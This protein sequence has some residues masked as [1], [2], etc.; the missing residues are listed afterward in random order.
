MPLLLARPRRH[1]GVLLVA[2][3]IGAEFAIA[4]RD[5]LSDLFVQ[6][7]GLGLLTLG[8][9]LLDHLVGHRA[10]HPFAR[11]GDVFGF[12]LPFGRFG[13]KAPIGTKVDRV[14]LGNLRKTQLAGILPGNRLGRLDEGLKTV[15]A[16]EE[17]P[18]EGQFVLARR[19][20]LVEPLL[21]VLGKIIVDELAEGILQVLADTVADKGWHQSPVLL[22]D[23]GT[24]K[25]RLDDGGVGARTTDTPVLH[26]LDQAGFGVTRSRLGLVGLLD[27][28][29]KR[30][31]L[32]Y[33]KGRQ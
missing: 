21:H 12:F 28:P 1:A 30:L 3:P 11:N 29:G 7:G 14:L 13:H 32:S 4:Q 22:L 20:N 2:A 16:L 31:R 17:A 33:R 15:R 8:N 24:V 26:L 19:G 25:Q 5:S 10:R 23:I 18:K 6:A 9:Q 27:Q